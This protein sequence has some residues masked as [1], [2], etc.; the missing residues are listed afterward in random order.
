M[1]DNSNPSLG[2]QPADAGTMA[3]LFRFVLKKFLQS[4]VDG[5][6]PCVVIAADADR[7]FVTVQ[8]S[9]MVQGTDKSLTSRAQ[10]AKVPVFTIG[11]GGFVLTFPIRPGDAGW[12]V[13]SDRDI[14]LYLQS[15]EA[16][17]PNT[18]RLHS[19]SDGLFIP[20]AARLYTL[21][22]E[23]DGSAVLQSLDGS[24]RVA[25]WPDRVKLTAPLVA[26]E[27]TSTTMTG[28]LT[29]DG[30]ISAGGVLAA[31]GEIHGASN[32]RV[33]GTAVV[34]GD[35]VA[36]S[37]TTPVSLSTHLH[38]GVTTGAAHTGPPG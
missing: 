32:L 31:A 7:K 3:G 2:Q 33:S 26:I 37:A 23:D 9:I 11:A 16:A 4:D 35:V 14:S 5:M 20:D 1:T 36:D 13:A 34:D 21:D 38:T 22:S 29:V 15:G 19:F 10:I 24:V 8:P 17:G 25:V 27:A 30:D 6:L 12:I 18:D 28:D